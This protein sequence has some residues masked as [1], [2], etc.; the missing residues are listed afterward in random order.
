MGKSPKQEGNHILNLVICSHQR[1]KIIIF[2]IRHLFVVR[3]CYCSPNRKYCKIPTKQA[4]VMYVIIITNKSF[5]PDSSVIV[6][7]TVIYPVKGPQLSQL[8]GWLTLWS[9]NCDV[10]VL[11]LTA[12]VFNQSA[13]LALHLTTTTAWHIRRKVLKARCVWVRVTVKN[14]IAVWK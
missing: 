1:Y 9:R 11:L 5:F 8:I 6:S 13:D 10:T 4:V 7:T 14:R 3:F 12:D 2:I